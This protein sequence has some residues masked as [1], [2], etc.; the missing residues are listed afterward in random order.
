MRPGFPLTVC[1]LLQET[2]SLSLE[3]LVNRGSQKGTLVY[4]VFDLLMLD[5]KDLRQLPLEKRKA[6]L[7]KLLTNHPRLLYVD[8]VETSGLGMFTCA[9]ALGLEGV[10]AKDAKSPSVEGTLTTWHWQ[11]IKNK[12]YQR[13]EPVEFHPRNSR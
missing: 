5:G 9:F 12:D 1:S 13:K 8:H 7:A 3:W 11:K 4:Y 10:V 6:R 2:V